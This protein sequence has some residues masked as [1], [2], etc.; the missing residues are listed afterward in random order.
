M[1]LWAQAHPAMAKRSERQLHESVQKALMKLFAQVKEMTAQQLDAITALFFDRK[2]T[3]A[4]LP[5]GH[6]KSFK[7]FQACFYET[8]I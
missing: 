2:R 4:V 1:H 3:F 7:F 5:T 6:G 8:L